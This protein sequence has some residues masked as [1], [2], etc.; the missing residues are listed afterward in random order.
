M[1][2][3]WIIVLRWKFFRIGIFVCLVFYCC[4]V[5][6]FVKMFVELERMIYFRCDIRIW[7]TGCDVIFIFVVKVFFLDRCSWV[8][9]NE[10][11]DEGLEKNLL[12]FKEIYYIL[13]FKELYKINLKKYLI[14]C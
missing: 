2:E 9:F 6:L 5:V 1:R 8:G 13:F 11:L 3:F 4:F 7:K 10:V 14:N 12:F